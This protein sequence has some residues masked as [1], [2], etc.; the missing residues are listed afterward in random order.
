MRSF[1]AAALLA[2]LLLGTACM[3][4]LVPVT[5]AE[6]P[7]MMAEETVLPPEGCHHEQQERAPAD[8]SCLN[9]CLSQATNRSLSSTDTTDPPIAALPVFCAAECNALEGVLIS[10]IGEAFHPSPPPTRTVVLL[11]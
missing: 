2:H 4:P 1:S 11:Q 7:V 6:E 5:A 3:M 10:P 9:H 8:A